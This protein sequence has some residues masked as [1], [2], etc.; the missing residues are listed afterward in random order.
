MRTARERRLTRCGMLLLLVPSTASTVFPAWL[1][2]LQMLGLMLLLGRRLMLLLGRRLWQTSVGAERVLGVK[3]AV[4][5][6]MPNLSTVGASTVEPKRRCAN[7]GYMT[8]MPTPAAG[9]SLTHRGARRHPRT[10]YLAPRCIPPWV[11]WTKGHK[12]VHRSR[13]R[14]L[15]GRGDTRRMWE[16]RMWERLLLRPL[17]SLSAAA[18]AAAVTPAAAASPPAQL[19]LAEA[20]TELLL[21]LPPEVSTLET[22]APIS[23]KPSG[24]PWA[25]A[26]VPRKAAGPK[27]EG[28]WVTEGGGGGELQRI[29]ELVLKVEL[30]HRLLEERTRHSTTEKEERLNGTVLG[31]KV[32][33]QHRHDLGLGN[34]TVGLSIRSKQFVETKE[35]VSRMFVCSPSESTESCFQ[36]LHLSP[37]RRHVACPNFFPRRRYA[38]QLNQLGT[39]R[40]A[41]ASAQQIGKSTLVVAHH[42]RSVLD[43]VV[44]LRWAAD[45]DERRT[46][47]P[48][49]CVV[50]PLV[51]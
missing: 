23:R 32:S 9:K 37:S 7:C 6:G 16:R 50:Q 4:P 5:E 31:G 41:L 26:S 48:V 2:Q 20:S 3:L 47:M 35:V 17:L 15:L 38:S 40:R 22:L 14:L 42:F 46:R 28:M 36:Y 44:S 18:A 24:P 34:H 1:L 30:Q 27:T 8:E 43:D 39:P 10:L 45:N 11:G 21:L 33:A 49:Q 29:A 13:C 25:A 51:V 12:V 19:L